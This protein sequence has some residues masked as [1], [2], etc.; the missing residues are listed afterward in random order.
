MLTADGCQERRRRLWAALDPAPDGVL[1]AEPAHLV[2]FANYYPTPFSFR[3]QN[4]RAILWLGADGSATL[5]A[6]NMQAAFLEGAHVDE[7]ATRDWYTGKA[8]APERN[9]VLIDAAADS[10]QDRARGRLAIDHGVPEALLAR[11]APSAT[12]TIASAIRRLRR[13]K[14]PDEVELMRR[15]IRAGEAG[16]DAASRGIVPGIREIDAYA[17]VQRA[18][19]EAA[20][21]PVVVYGDFVS[22]PR[23][24]ERGGM[25]TSRVIEDGDLFLLDFSV[26]V[27]G[28]RGDFTNTFVVGDRDPTA[29]ER[30][31]EAV[32]LE[33]LRTGE[34]LLKAE[35]E[36]RAID[37]AVR[38]VYRRH[39]VEPFPHH[40]GHGLGLGHPDPPYLTPE[41]PDVLEAGDVVT[42]E[43]GAYEKGVGGMRFERNYLITADGCEN[44][45]HHQLGLKTVK[46]R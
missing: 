14:L 33:A 42:L 37:A 9:G 30:E 46:S 8:S 3:S 1:L 7:R 19:V 39:G 40:T 41:S 16:F 23:T 5:V 45:T 20:G 28:Y 34:P 31:L 35:A 25:A 13:N 43:P 18:A 32:C 4:A 44:L 26:V 15:S 2:Y 12:T 24:V 21:E 38:E 29:R 11:L 6:D 36:A 22:G 27:R 17:L 10:L